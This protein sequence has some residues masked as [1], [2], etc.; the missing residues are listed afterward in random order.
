MGWFGYGIYDGDGTQTCHI[1]F[2]NNA[3][4]TKSSTDEALDLLAV[5]G[6]ILP[7]DMMQKFVNNINKVLKKMPKLVRGYFQDEDDAIEW[8]MLL[9]LFV[10]NKTTP[11]KEIFDIGFEATVYLDGEHAEGFDQP[12]ERHRVLRNFMS[13]AKEVYYQSKTKAKCKPMK[14]ETNKVE[15]K[16]AFPLI[17]SDYHIFDDYKYA[18]KKAGVRV[19]FVEVGCSGEYCAVFYLH[20]CRKEAQPLINKLKKKYAY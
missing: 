12:I 14:K 5:N 11:L 19:G 3:G 9:A 15:I 6:T 16:K 4:V 20:G 10:D 8:Q 7:A 13:K 17:A 18:L 2:L 1:D